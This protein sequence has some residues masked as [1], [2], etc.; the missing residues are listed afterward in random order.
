MNLKKYKFFSCKSINLLYN[1]IPI[2]IFTGTV[3][4]QSQFQ[5]IIGGT[6]SDVAWSITLS[7]DGGY[8]T[9]GITSSFGSGFNDIYLIKFDANGAVQWTKTIGG[10]KNDGGNSIIR[11]TDNGYAVAGTTLSYGAGN[12]DFFI[13]KLDVNGAVQWSRTIGGAYLETALSITQTTDGG[14]AVTGFTLS[15]GSPPGYYDMYVVKLDSG[16]SLQ[17]SSSIGSTGND[18]AYSIVQSSD[19][20]YAVAGSYLK[21][22]CIVKLN[23]DGTLQWSKIM[24]GIGYCISLIRTADN[25]YA[26]TGYKYGISTTDADMCIVKLD[27][28]GTVQWSRTIGGAYN[29]QGAC[30]IQTTDGGYAVSG[31]TD[32]LGTGLY[33]V[34]LVKL[35]SNGTVQWSKTTGGNSAEYGWTIVQTTDGGYAVAGETLSFGESNDVYFVKLDAFGNTCVNSTSRTAVLGTTNAFR[36]ITPTVTA[37]N[38]NVTSPAPIISSGGNLTSVCLTG[39][40]NISNEIPSSFS[41]SQNYPNPF[42]P[43][44]IINYQ[45]PM[46]NFV[47]LI[48]YDVMGKEIVTLVNEQLKSGTYEVEWNASEFPSGVYFYRLQTE[49]FKE[50]K[51]MILIK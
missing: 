35:D 36:S 51:R 43:K 31:L 15:F 28:N 12:Y 9:S 2:L 29:D 27:S 33:D 38:S 16:G 1:I 7:A 3:K 47:K 25:G 50:T 45:L 23:S 6:N 40:Q 24:D 17:W 10:I 18:L 26:M 21:Q 32:S 30:I 8:V 44:T 39:K 13:V 22:F 46:S 42:N 14:Y 37:Q 48:I 5:S 34:Y 41:L 19:G 11:T 20:G 49:S 4:P